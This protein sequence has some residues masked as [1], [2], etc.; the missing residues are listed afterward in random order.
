MDNENKELDEM[1]KRGMDDLG[2]NDTEI[3]E[4]I[5]HFVENGEKNDKPVDRVK[6]DESKNEFLTSF[7]MLFS[8]KLSL[9]WNVPLNSCFSS[10]S[11]VIFSSF[12]IYYTS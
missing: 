11:S 1:V 2:K 6:I 9:S 4:K 8:V 5:E 12:S 10:N 3:D 7:T